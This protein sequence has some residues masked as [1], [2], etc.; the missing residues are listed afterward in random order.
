MPFRFLL[1]MIALVSVVL[2]P[3]AVFAADAGLVPSA[4][5]G[6]VLQCSLCD[7][8]VLI[9]NIYMWL[10][11]IAALFAI[12]LLTYAGVQMIINS[13]NPGKA[14]K[15][16]GLIITTLI[17]LAIAFGSWLIV[18]QV[19]LAVGGDAIQRGGPNG[20]LTFSCTGSA[21]QIGLNENVLMV[22]LRTTESAALNPPT[23][24]PTGTI[25]SGGKIATSLPS[26]IVSNLNPLAKTMYNN[27]L[28]NPSAYNQNNPNNPTYGPTACAR[29]MNKL[30]DN[31]GTFIGLVPDTVSKGAHPPD[32]FFKNLAD[33]YISKGEVLQTHT[34]GE[35]SGEHWTMVLDMKAQ[36]DGSYDIYFVDPNGY[37][38]SGK[39]ALIRKLNSKDKF[40]DT[41]VKYSS[42][43]ND[44]A[45]V[46]KSR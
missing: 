40:W 21:A 37:S 8:L 29:N 41:N 34:R 46:Y 36:S 19:L 39:P 31:S 3:V 33:T 26:D 1:V 7:V 38:G 6:D 14:E 45:A 9:H 32:S 28:M 35:G 10:L 27:Y 20:F 23:S 2:F 30:G 22:G 15:S 5:Q 18:D 12:G 13:A 42:N 43:A 16:R 25:T 24:N 11:G 44:Y 17:G 4:C